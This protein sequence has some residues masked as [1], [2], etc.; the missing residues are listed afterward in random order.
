MDDQ[1]VT[2]RPAR[3]R[4][5]SWRAPVVLLLIV[6]AAAAGSVAYWY[7]TKDVETTDDAFTDGRAITVASQVAG[8]VVALNVTDNQHVQAGDV[9]LQIDPR[10]Y[11]AAR[12]AATANLQAAQAQLDT[13]RLNLETARV[14][15]PARLAAAQATLAM[16]EASRAK[17]EA[18]A[19]RQQS[20]PK[21][22]TSQQDIDSANA[23]LQTTAAQVQQA[24]ATVRE[25]DQLG[26]LIAQSAVQVRQLEAQVALAR[27]QLD[28]AAL[29]LEWTR[30]TAP[31][32]GWVTRRNVEM[33]NDVQ[34][35]QALLALVTP[36]V[37]V[38]AN[39]KESQLDHMRPGQR[40]DISVDA[41]PSLH[42]TGHIDSIQL[43]SGSRFTAFPP[44]NAT[45]NF[46]KIVQR[47]P[48]K[49]VIDGGLPPGLRLPLGLSVTPVVHIR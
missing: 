25:A 32:E 3:V 13:A 41:Y 15:Y 20:L 22:A 5:R 10:S 38:T 8:L 17:A 21:A 27:A 44:E 1:P 40:V 14:N 19:K 24:E 33:G 28:Q 31:Q 49:I 2:L 29:N 43:G 39:F 30:V 46:V 4:T 26:N 12:D 34:A 9:L 18:D 11:T 42:L 16:A 48:V 35:G 45:G 37:W 23:N 36:E 47:V 7:V 6:L